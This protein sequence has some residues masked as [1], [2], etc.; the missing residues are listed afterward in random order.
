[1]S[2]QKNTLPWDIVESALLSILAIALTLLPHSMAGFS[3]LL[4]VILAVFIPGYAA[5][6]ALFPRASD[7]ALKERM[8]LSL[9][10]DAVIAVLT[11]LLLSIMGRIA[12][13]TLAQALAIISLPLIA[14]AYIRWALLPS[15]WRFIPSF[16]SNSLQAG[17]R[18]NANEQRRVL[19]ILLSLAAIIIV[20]A[21]DYS[22]Y[23]NINNSANTITI[24]STPSPTENEGKRLTEFY[25]LDD[26]AQSTIEAGS[27]STIVAGIVN[28]EQRTSDYTLRLV[29]NGSIL[30][31]KSVKLKHN[32]SWEGALSYSIDSPANMQR[33]DLLLYRDGDFK[34]PYDERN[35]WVNVSRQ[36]EA[37]NA[38][39]EEIKSEENSVSKQMDLSKN[40]DSRLEHEGDSSTLAANPKS[41]RP[42]SPEEN[43]S[44]IKAP[45][46]S[47]TSSNT[48]SAQLSEQRE[49]QKKNASEN[50]SEAIAVK[51]I[52][53]KPLEINESGQNITL[54]LSSGVKTINASEAYQK[55]YE[56]NKKNENGEGQG[57]NS[58]SKGSES[59]L[60]NGF[61]SFSTNTS[62]PIINNKAATNPTTNPY[63]AP[64]KFYTRGKPGSSTLKKTNGP[65]TATISEKVNNVSD[66]VKTGANNN[67]TN[68]NFSMIQVAALASGTDKSGSSGNQQTAAQKVSD[69]SNS[70]TL[71]HESA[72][73]SKDALNSVASSNVASSNSTAANV[74]KQANKSANQSVNASKS[75]S[76]KPKTS[77]PP[78]EESVR[79]A[80]MSK[81]I[82]S[83]VSSRG[84]NPS[85]SSNSYE[86]DIIK[87]NNANKSV[88]L[89][90][91]STKTKKLG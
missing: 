22:S 23:N 18:K 64:Q 10:G 8:L 81:K 46:P 25:I 54:N 30:S 51:N 31:E 66:A 44:E 49:E 37:Q 33:I 50:L 2:R 1:M 65:E 87:F 53:F 79:M 47:D 85:S 12:L 16:G 76:I 57:N 68:N 56:S 82:D 32:N 71:Q 55:A 60:N 20:S 63:S 43:K 58:I 7:L 80:E 75:I 67:K 48:S 4:A 6:L 39:K 84:M 29:V 78:D 59:S 86:S 73:I 77:A 14:V 38:A 15:G 42:S 91:G 41:L 28:R 35:I 3:S 21:L 88:I 74:T 19:V 17:R 36:E 5:V 72:N 89:G 90:G 45:Q 61:K 69:K 62:I 13:S 24:M 9:G 52:S 34:K 27:R 40:G 11:A 83:W 26:S 70:D